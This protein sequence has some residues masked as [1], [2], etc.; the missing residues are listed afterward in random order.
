MTPVPFLLF[1]AVA[2]TLAVVGAQGRLGR[3]LVLQSLARGWVVEG[4]VRRPSDPIPTPTRNG[5]LSEGPT[6]DA[7]CVASPNLTLVTDVS[8]ALD[9]DGIVFCVGAEPFASRE[10]ASLQTDAVRRLL[11][12]C[13]DDTRVCL[14]SAHGAAESLNASNLGIKFMHSVYLREA[15]AAKEEQE[16]LV[17]QRNLSSLILRPRVLSFSRIP[18]NR[19]ATPRSELAARILDWFADAPS[20]D[21]NEEGSPQR[22]P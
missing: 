21:Q 3:E 11:A 14:V 22:H 9:V 8:A 1:G 20:N 19:V 15:Y 16:R 6:D 17:A 2:Y 12:R 18:L 7:A 4:I 13:S 10:T 5:W